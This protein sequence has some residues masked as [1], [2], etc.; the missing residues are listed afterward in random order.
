MTLTGKRVLVVEDEVVIAMMV[1]D[2]LMDLGAEVVGPA[3][4]VE[5]AIEVVASQAVDV[6]LLDMNLNG[7]NSDRVADAL[8]ARGVPF[9]YATG[10]GQSAAIQGQAEIIEKPYR[11]ENMGLALLRALQSKA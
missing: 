2:M 9:V 1:E 3:A 8:K 4:T 6:A 5:R 11:R 10:Y 7:E